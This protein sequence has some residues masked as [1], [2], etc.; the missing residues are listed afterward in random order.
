MTRLGWNRDARLQVKRE[1]TNSRVRKRGQRRNQLGIG[2]ETREKVKKKGGGW[3]FQL[4][5]YTLILRKVIMSH[6]VPVFSCFLL[7]PFLISV[8]RLAISH[9]PSSHSHWNI[10]ACLHAS[11]TIQPCFLSPVQMYTESLARNWAQSQSKTRAG[12]GAQLWGRRR[13]KNRVGALTLVP[14]LSIIVFVNLYWGVFCRT[15]IVF[16]IV[17]ALSF[18]RYATVQKMTQSIWII[19]PSSSLLWNWHVPPSTS[20]CC[21]FVLSVCVPVTHDRISSVCLSV[22][23]NT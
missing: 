11:P 17:L 5:L 7:Y 18:S 16:D 14:L 22:S 1:G 6:V 20:P 10:S 8:F 23:T 9:F 12:F 21:L 19:W 13:R 15:P 2:K 4:K 3:P